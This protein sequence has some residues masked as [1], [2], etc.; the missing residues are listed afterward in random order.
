MIDYQWVVDV[1]FPFVSGELLSTNKNQG[2]WTRWGK[3]CISL[4]NGNLKIPVRE[5][6]ILKWSLQIGLRCKTGWKETLITDIRTPAS[7][8]SWL[9]DSCQKLKPVSDTWW[10]ESQGPPASTLDRYDLKFTLSALIN[11]HHFGQYFKDYSF[12][13]RF[14]C[15]TAILRSRFHPSPWPPWPMSWL[16]VLWQERQ[17]ALDAIGLQ[18]SGSC[19]DSQWII[20]IPRKP[21]YICI[22][23]YIYIYM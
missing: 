14:W 1:P 17:V 6:S 21:R 2:L 23:I 11:Q 19:W 3:S 7:A 5:G 18:E 8:N 9:P 10:M 20:I 15:G 16:Q 22:C 4:G 12:V 13:F